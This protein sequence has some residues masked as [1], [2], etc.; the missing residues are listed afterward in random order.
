MN[1]YEIF[2]LE[3]GNPTYAYE[4]EEAVQD[5]YLVD[6]RTI[7]STS[8]FMDDGIRYDDLS[9]EEQELYEETFIEDDIGDNISGGAL[10]EWLFYYKNVDKELCDFMVKGSKV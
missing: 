10:N 7:E 9:E 3:S 4:L 5:G 2:G 6:Y 8:K 1:T